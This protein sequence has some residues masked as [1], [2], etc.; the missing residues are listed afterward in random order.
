[1]SKK[2]LYTVRPSKI[3]YDGINTVHISE[4][5]SHE[6]EV[7]SQLINIHAVHSQ[8]K[9]IVEEEYEAQAAWQLICK[10]LKSRCS[11]EPL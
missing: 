8:G 3:T 10:Q 11:Y 1:M 5:L 2:Q 7:F 4:L 6:T 9:Y